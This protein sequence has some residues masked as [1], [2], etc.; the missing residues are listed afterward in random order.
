MIK[1]N[2]PFT[3]A[4]RNKGKSWQIICQVE[5]KSILLHNISYEAEP[6]SY[7]R[8]K[9]NVELDLSIYV[10][11]SEVKKTTGVNMSDFV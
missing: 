6:D 3:Y 9:I 11:K 4:L 1:N 7:G 8:N 2:T 5:R 10:T